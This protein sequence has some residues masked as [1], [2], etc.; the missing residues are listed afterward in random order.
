MARARARA[1]VKPAG[2]T[3]TVNGDASDAEY[4]S[5]PVNWGTKRPWCGLGLGPWLGFRL[6]LRLR[7]RLRLRLIGLWA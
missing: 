7:I 2:R 1:S 3:S 6:M 4:R 5:K